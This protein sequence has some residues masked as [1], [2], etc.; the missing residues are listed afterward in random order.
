MQNKVH[1]TYLGMG[2]RHHLWEINDDWLLVIIDHD[3]ELVEVTVDDAV[4]GELQQQV[5]QF[6]VQC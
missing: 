4:I 5:H 3:V 2:C 6:V 1:Y